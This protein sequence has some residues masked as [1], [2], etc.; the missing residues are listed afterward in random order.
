MEKRPQ[1]TIDERV[2]VAPDC[3]MLARFILRLIDSEPI[4][5]FVTCKISHKIQFFPLILGH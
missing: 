3:F 5:A 4:A 1:F 2:H